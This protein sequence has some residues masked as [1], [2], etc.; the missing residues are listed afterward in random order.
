MTPE[1]S[2]SQRVRLL[3]GQV[4]EIMGA[5]REMSDIRIFRFV[6]GN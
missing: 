6:E 1:G 2:E 5:I 3:S 4:V